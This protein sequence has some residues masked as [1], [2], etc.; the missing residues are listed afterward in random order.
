[1][2]VLDCCCADTLPG[3]AVL[4]PGQGHSTEHVPEHGKQS[5]LVF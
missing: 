4:Y 1:M 5:S 2:E 3:S